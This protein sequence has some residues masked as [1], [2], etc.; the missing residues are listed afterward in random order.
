MKETSGVFKGRGKNKIQNPLTLKHAYDYYI[1]DIKLNSKY[2]IDW[3]LYKKI[4]GSFN[5]IVMRKIIE[6]G[7]IFKV[8]YRL[9]SIR[10]IKRKNRLDNLKPDYSLY[11][12]S[13]GKYKVKHLNEHTD[14]YYVRF[15]WYKKE[16]IVINKTIYSFIPTRANKRHLASLLKN[17]GIEQLNKYFE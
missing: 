4:V 12:T 15:H 3:S 10:V 14:N 7:Y 2:D 6:D 8:P 17:K 5:K 1:K 9:G 16:S 11:N 13:E